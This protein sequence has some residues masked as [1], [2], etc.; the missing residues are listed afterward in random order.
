MNLSR[1]SIVAVFLLGVSFAACNTS[2]PSVGNPKVAD[3][4]VVTDQDDSLS[5]QEVMAG[6]AYW[7]SNQ[8]NN[9]RLDIQRNIPANVVPNIQIQAPNVN[10]SQR[11]NLISDATGYFVLQ[12]QGN[13][14]VLSIGRTLMND[15]ANAISLPKTVPTSP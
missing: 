9:K 1:R 14:R 3:P 15:G 13:R 4:A 11:W 10:F 5:A 7:I 8:C 6:M 2:S 12:S